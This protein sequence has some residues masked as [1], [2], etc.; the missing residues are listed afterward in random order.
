MHSLNVA[1]FGESQAHGTI[2]VV[3]FLQLNEKRKHYEGVCYMQPV[4]I[5]A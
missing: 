3:E 5:T 4:A 1:V 2:L